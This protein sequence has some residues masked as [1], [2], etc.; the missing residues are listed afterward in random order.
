[1]DDGLP[2]EPP[3]GDGPGDGSDPVDDKVLVQRVAGT[4]ELERRGKDGIEVAAGI[5]TSCGSSRND[6]I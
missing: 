1:M 4:V 6:E 5:V 2:E 3:G